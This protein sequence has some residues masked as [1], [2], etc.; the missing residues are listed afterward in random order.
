VLISRERQI[1][2][3]GAYYETPYG[4]W[5]YTGIG[6][7]ERKISMTQSEAATAARRKFT[8]YFA[9]A[10]AGLL[11]TAPA[12]LRARDIPPI[13]SPDWLSKNLGDAKLVILDIRSNE[14]YKK[15][16]IPGA[17]NVSMSAWAVSRN[18]L[19]LELP[20]ES[21]L[22]EIIGKSGIDSSSHVVIVN[23]ID[24][25]FSRADATRVAWTCIVAGVPNASVLDGGH[26]RWVR[27]IKTLST[28]VSEPAP[29]KYAGRVHEQMLVNQ[30]V[31]LARIGKSIIVDT[32][33]PE[34]YFGITARPGHIKSAVNLPT[35]W[36][37]SENG[38]FRKEEELKAMADGVIGH[39]KSKEVIFYCGVG[40]Y[41]TT[42]W[43]LL[44]QVFGYQKAKVFDGSMEEWLKDPRAPVSS[45]SWNQ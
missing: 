33:T 11:L 23:R 8:M 12:V 1:L 14:Q 44:T 26:N 20:A 35:P 41:A 25:D 24:T 19:S 18:G 5:T 16:H 10:I 29:R 34:D 22:L 45:Y 30:K 17:I 28:Q 6:Y 9:L 38:T 37:F 4:S 32:R 31:V 36:V 2:I 21:E 15:G 27:E 39:N 43:F 3:A 42:W 40:G 13:V 7:D